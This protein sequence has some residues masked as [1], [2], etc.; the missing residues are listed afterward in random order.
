VER[1]RGDPVSL[2]LARAFA[3]FFA[4]ILWVAA[5][6]ALL[7]ERAQ[8]GQGMA[9]LAIAILGVIVVNGVFSFWQEAK[10]E[11]ALAELERLLPQDVKAIRGGVERVVPREELV[12][13]DVIVVEEGDEVP[14][15]ARVIEAHRLRVV[16]AAMTGE[17]EPTDRDGEPSTAADPALASN[18][19]LAGT[20][21]VAGRGR[22]VVVAIGMATALGK[23]ASLTQSAGDALSPLQKEMVRV[24]RALAVVAGAL[25]AVF[26]GIGR[27]LHLPFWDSFLFGIGILVANVPEGLLPTV[28]LALAM[29]SQR[30]A[31]RNVLIR[32]LPAVETLGSTT[33]ICSD[34]TGTLTQNRMEVVRAYVSGREVAAA[35]FSVGSLGASLVGGARAC[36]SLERVVEEGRERLVGDPMEVALVE[37]AARIGA[38]EEPERVDEIPFDADRKRLTVLVSERGRLALFT[39]GA[40]ETVLPLCSRIEEGGGE[41]P[42][43]VADCERVIAAQDTMARSGLRV[44]A[45]AHK[46]VAEKAD[47]ASL[48]RDLVLSGLVA[49]HDPPRPEV[50]GAVRSCRAAGVRTIMVTGD[51]PATAVAI[52]REIDMV[53]GESPVVVTG[54][55]LSRM[56]DAQLG[57]SLDAEEVIF[58]RTKPE[59]KMRIVQ[60]L[61]RKKH[62]VAVTGDGVNDAPA[63]KCA[64]VGVAMGKTGTDVARGAADIVLADDNFASIVAGIEEGRAAFANIRKFL[65]YILTSNVPELVPYLL[66]VLLKIPLPLTVAQ[67][68][69]VDLGTDMMP[70]LALGIE[71]PDPGAMEKPPRPREERLLDAKLLLRAYVFLGLFESAAALAGFYFV[72]HASGWVYGQQ[73][74]AAPIYRE[75]TAATFAGIVMAQIANLFLCRSETR[76]A[77]SMGLGQNRWIWIGLSV[78]IAILGFVVFTPWGQALFGTAPVRPG[79]WLFVVPFVAA[80]IGAEELRKAWARRGERRPGRKELVAAPAAGE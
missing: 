48:E 66:F 32:H 41:R 40:V 78:E 14:A 49:L 46:G 76:S 61:Q 29:A 37:A 26:F 10:A 57:L 45:F 31:K 54:P 53:R 47:P 63:L 44:L 2:R 16:E 4:V 27:A 28:T 15:D 38:G 43:S 19:L 18:M 8:P 1:S 33:V 9:T 42:I 23:I 58:A 59:Q 20:S 60:A 72:L 52:A 74:V 7:A 30:M 22:A 62:V 6:L 3:N 79:A 69:A 5:G 77:F 25:G 56:S 24:S 75:A 12:P 55:E 80:M 51:H 36:H 68:L 67:I 73:A 64:D 35:R 70:A 71:P 21:V 65:T 50:A 11:R 34:K 17:A 13:G 39:K